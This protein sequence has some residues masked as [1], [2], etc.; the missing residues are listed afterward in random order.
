MIDNTPWA[1]V[2][3]VS[4]GSGSAIAR[5]LAKDAHLHVFGVHRGNR[6]ADAA[7]VEAAIAAADRRCHMRVAGAGTYEEVVAGADELLQVAG[8]KSVKI[9]VH[10]IAN[11]SY[12]RYVTGDGAWIAPKQI[13]KTFDCMAHSFLWWVQE[14]V[15]RDLLAPGARLVALSNPLVDTVV[16]GWGPVVASKA[17]LEAYV[18][19]LADELGPQGHCVTLLKFSMVET[20]AVQ[21]AFSA[22]AWA[23]FRREAVAMMPCR[24]LCELDEVAAMVVALVGEVGTWFNGCTIDYTGSQNRSL[25]DYTF[26]PERRKDYE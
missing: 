24:R 7:E 13:A 4:G 6:K 16:H 8:P 26:H 21:V 1:L 2:L 12:G 20:R 17:A 10:S 25:L 11:A 23:R 14:L 9:L 19:Y 22:E 5:A 18:R 15:R 3:G